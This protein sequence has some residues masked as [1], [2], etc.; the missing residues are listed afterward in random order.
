M[1][2]YHTSTLPVRQ[3]PS[4][5]SRK[6]VY[7]TAGVQERWKQRCE[8]VAD[9]EEPG[10][11]GVDGAGNLGSL[12]PPPL[13]NGLPP[14]GNNT[15]RA[16]LSEFQSTVDSRRLEG[17]EQQAPARA[18]R[19]QHHADISQPAQ[20]AAYTLQLPPAQQSPA[21]QVPA[22]RGASQLASQALQR[23]VTL[24]E[25]IRMTNSRKTVPADSSMP[26]GHPIAPVH[27]P[28]GPPVPGKS[29][30]PLIQPVHLL[31]AAVQ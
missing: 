9:A 10:Q 3:P 28:L 11:A 26:T 16:R 21:E 17:Q 29:H 7:N 27:S 31:M 22:E 15:K 25:A 12:P 2:P 8:H 5:E 19:R 14:D 30:L 23:P 6:E 20:V 4:A 1:H 13:V 24:P 18:G